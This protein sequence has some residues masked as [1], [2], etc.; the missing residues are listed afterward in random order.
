MLSKLPG[1]VISNHESVER[2]AAQYRDM[3]V[4]QRL[5]ILAGLCRTVPKLLEMNSQRE[6]VIAYRAPL[7][8]SSQRALARLRDQMKSARARRG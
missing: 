8:Q 5:E 6:F 7:P 2:E 3:T 4:E 1:W